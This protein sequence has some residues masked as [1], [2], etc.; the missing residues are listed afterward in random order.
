MERRDFLK[1]GMLGIAGIGLVGTGNQAQAKAL[2]SP[3]KPKNIIFMVSDGM[4]MG[5]PSL[6][7]P[8]SRGVRGKGTAFVDLM[9]NRRV[10]KGFFDTAS[11]DTLVTDSAAAGS[12]WGSGSRVNNGALNTLPDGTV[13]T[14]IGE[15]VQGIG[16]KVGLVTTTEITHA[17]PASFVCASKSRSSQEEIAQLMMNRA[18]FLMGGGNDHFDPSLRSDQKDVYQAYREAGYAIVRSK[19]EMANLKPEQKALG[20]FAN[21][22]LPYTVDH[23]NS[24]ELKRSVPTLAEMT[25]RA[26]QHLEKSEK[27]FLL[28]VEGGRIDHAAHGND[29]AAILWDQL[30]FDDAVE[31]ALAFARAKGDTLVVVTSDHGNANPGLNGIGSRYE[32]STQFFERVAPAKA[33]Y[34]Q[35]QEILKVEG[36]ESATIQDVFKQTLGLEIS[37]VEAQ[38]LAQSFGSPLPP[39]IHLQHNNPSGIWGQVIG[40]HTGIGWVGTTH[41]ND[42]T[43]I[44]AEGPGQELFNGFLLN[45]EAFE[46]VTGLW[47][48]EFRNPKA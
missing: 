28:Q 5:V 33:S 43:L 32:R 1:S 30:A 14:T 46:L 10:A 26:L 11:L 47:D 2:H 45:T 42:Y 48:L 13:L 27:G 39:E 29:T 3:N 23:L 8:F 25:E 44:L 20:I 9:S 16:K 31:V 21:G 35:I 24:E 36:L 19:E 17:T 18:D 4:S 22:H 37:N 6:A 7:E 38:I 41:T 34:G 12:A 15:L 40:N